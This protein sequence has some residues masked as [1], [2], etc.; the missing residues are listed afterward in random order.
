MVYRFS[1]LNRRCLP[2]PPGV[3]VEST[4]KLCEGGLSSSLV[5]VCSARRSRAVSACCSGFAS[6]C[7]SG[8]SVARSIGTPVDFCAGVSLTCC[9]GISLVSGSGISSPTL[10]RSHVRVLRG[11]S[12]MFGGGNTGT[13]S[14][15]DHS[16]TVVHRVRV[17]W[18]PPS[19]MLPGMW[20][21][22]VAVFLFF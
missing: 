2:E 16:I 8:T 22:V 18:S 1:F 19:E 20:G 17:V 11:G 7:C 21:V 13:S 15:S 6:V 4:P 3:A 10:D 9:S 12:L 5:D 14:S